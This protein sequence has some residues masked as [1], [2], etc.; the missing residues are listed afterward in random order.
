M[1]MSKTD[2]KSEEFDKEEEEVIGPQRLD[3]W[4]PVM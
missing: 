4:L 2:S 1:M 3:A